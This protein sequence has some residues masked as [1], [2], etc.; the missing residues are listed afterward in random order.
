MKLIILVRQTSFITPLLLPPK[1]ECNFSSRQ[2]G[3]HSCYI[4]RC[5]YIRPVQRRHI[6]F[7]QAELD[8]MSGTLHCEEGDY[9]T[10][11]SYFLES[12]EAFDSQEDARA[13][14]SLKVSDLHER[15]MCTTKAL[16][17]SRRPTALTDEGNRVKSFSYDKR[18]TI[19]RSTVV[20]QRQRSR[21]R[22]GTLEL[23][24]MPR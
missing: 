9:K 24:L 10:S 12:Y 3:L 5:L 2:H 8:D 20:C 14:R 13:L 16:P 11:F 23:L 19:P 15:D 4:R 21:E 6:T 18:S 7:E 17:L 22:R 1:Q